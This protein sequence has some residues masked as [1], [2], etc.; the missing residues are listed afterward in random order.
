[1]GI[2]GRITESWKIQVCLSTNILTTVQVPGAGV[3]PCGT[4]R[5]TV[6][7]SGRAGMASVC[8]CASG[9]TKHCDGSS[10]NSLHA[11]AARSE[12]GVL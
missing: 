2:V 4:W 5:S 3:V 7:I 1:M 11:R 9:S 10:S 12:E 8:A 6:I